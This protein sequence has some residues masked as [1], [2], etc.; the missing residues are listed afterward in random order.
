MLR[1][2][3]LSTTVLA[4]VLLLANCQAVQADMV[5]YELGPFQVEGTATSAPGAQ[6]D[7]F[8]K[9]YDMLN[10]IENNLP[11]GHVLLQFVIE[12]QGWTS[13]T[14]YTIDFHVLIWIPSGPNPNGSI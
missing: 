6:A 13:A 4:L 8:A 12:D 3:N 5:T 7:A 1:A 10:E 2:M 11:E 9:L 14:D